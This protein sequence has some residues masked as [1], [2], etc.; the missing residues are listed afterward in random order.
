MHR[1]YE[2]KMKSFVEEKKKELEEKMK[3]L[4]VEKEREVEEQVKNVMHE[5]VLLR[6]RLKIEQFQVKLCD[7]S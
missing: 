1:E 6:T 7:D 5:N 2:D 3:M 4:K